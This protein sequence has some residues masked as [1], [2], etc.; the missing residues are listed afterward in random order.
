MTTGAQLIA[1]ILRPMRDAAQDFFP[2]QELLDYINEAADDLALREQL[3]RE[4]TTLVASGGVL[5]YTGSPEIAQIR[6][7]KN[8][9]GLEVAFMDES[10]FFEYQQVG[11]T[12]LVGTTY[13]QKIHIDPAPTD[14]ESWTVGYYGLP[15]PLATDA[16]T[17]GLSRQWETKV[18]AY[19]KAECYK[20]LGEIALAAAEEAKYDAGLRPAAFLTDRNTPGRVN[21]AREANVFDVDV[22]SIHLGS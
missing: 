19:G 15:T 9:N 8:P 18:V 2:D 4:Q 11:G 6:W 13:D 22:D 16:G 20:R 21:F 10:T 7:V 17:F 14:G 3:I 1:R 5:D 12:D